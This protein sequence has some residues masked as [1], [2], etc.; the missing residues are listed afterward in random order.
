[1]TLQESAKRAAVYSV[2]VGVLIM[3]VVI[4]DAATLAYTDS[5]ATPTATVTPAPI[6]LPADFKAGPYSDQFGDVID[7]SPTLVTHYARDNHGN[8]WIGIGDRRYF[9]TAGGALYRVED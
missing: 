8:E 1:V 6:V 3:F 4:G 2:A 9:R 5:Q 7:I